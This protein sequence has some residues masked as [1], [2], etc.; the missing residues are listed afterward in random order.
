MASPPYHKTIS[1]TDRLRGPARG[2]RDLGYPQAGSCAPQRPCGARTDAAQHAAMV[3]SADLSRVG[4]AEIGEEHPR[5]ASQGRSAREAT[6]MAAAARRSRASDGQSSASLRRQH[7]RIGNSCRWLSGQEALSA[8]LMGMS[9]AFAQR[10]RSSA[11]GSTREGGDACRQRL[12]DRS[13]PETGGRQPGVRVRQ[14]ALAAQLTN[15]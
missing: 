10:L 9:S 5:D 3:R 4:V 1:Q 2:R 8:L 13:S 15:G 6:T 11:V 14:H 7:S 12:R